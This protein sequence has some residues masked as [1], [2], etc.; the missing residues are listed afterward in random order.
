[1]GNL[2]SECK[3]WNLDSSFSS[4]C[5][6]WLH[7]F[8]WT[9]S[10]SNPKILFCKNH[11]QQINKNRYGTG[12]ELWAIFFLTVSTVPYHTGS[13]TKISLVRL[14]MHRD[15]DATWSK[16]RACE[17]GLSARLQ[18]SPKDLPNRAIRKLQNEIICGGPR[19]RILNWRQI[20]CSML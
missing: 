16:T 1:M 15:H 13:N 4:L 17:K 8:E 5:V 3:S 18:P 7:C 20:A 9:C 12:H 14:R 2:W 19:L 11:E 10:L 6:K